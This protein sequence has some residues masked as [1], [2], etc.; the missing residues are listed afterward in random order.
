MKQNL[1]QQ[2]ELTQ[3]T[4]AEQNNQILLLQ[5]VE[6]KISSKLK[7]EKFKEIS[8]LSF[9][10]LDEKLYFIFGGSIKDVLSPLAWVF[11]I[12]TSSIIKSLSLPTGMVN[13]KAIGFD[14]KVYIFGAE[15]EKDSRLPPYILD[16]ETN[17][18]KI[19][20]VI[21]YQYKQI[22]GLFVYQNVIILVFNDAR[23]VCFEPKTGEWSFWKRIQYKFDFIFSDNDLIYFLDTFQ[24][25]IYE[26]DIEKDLIK[27]K[28]MLDFEVNEFMFSQ[29]SRKLFLLHNF[30]GN[31]FYYELNLKNFELLTCSEKDYKQFF[32]NGS[33]VRNY[34]TFKIGQ[35]SKNKNKIIS[36]GNEKKVDN[37]GLK[38]FNKGVR[39]N[40]TVNQTTE[41]KEMS[42]NFTILGC[43]EAP[44]HF[45]VDLKSNTFSLN[46]ISSKLALRNHQ[47][48]ML[49][50]SNKVILAG[51][52]KGENTEKN[53]VDVQQYNLMTR[54]VEDL[55]DMPQE[56]NNAYLADLDTHLILLHDSDMMFKYDKKINGWDRLNRSSRDV[57]CNNFVFKSRL[58]VFYTKKNSNGK[59]EL[60]V[61][62]YNGSSDSWKLTIVAEVDFRI[63]AQ[64]NIKCNNNQVLMICSKLNSTSIEKIP[65][66]YELLINEKQNS[67]F[68]PNL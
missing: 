49:L 58:F 22:V 63:Q 48:Y 18:L 65:Y 3:I 17:E 35:D 31:Q 43:Y 29:P 44:F 39:V 5:N 53:E 23:F 67:N 32:F 68:V 28:M 55:Q 40:Q 20:S 24:S 62:E 61:E 51:G 21:P 47:G 13:G 27:V 37:Q 12:Q 41:K 52:R 60:V 56:T 34:A 2:F 16:L 1:I 15:K 33:L 42:I 7:N 54:N 6:S 36:F 50:Q 25:T 4:D 8:N 30:S 46:P 66:F 26:Y 45:M 10:Q 59:M 57:F 11:D 64:S 9:C 19:L 14:K 38:H